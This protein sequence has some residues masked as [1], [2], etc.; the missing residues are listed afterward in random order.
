MKSLAAKHHPLS[1]AA[2]QVQLLE[3]P[4]HDIP[5]FQETLE[6]HGI[7]SLRSTALGTLQ[8]NIGKMCNQTCVHCHVDAGPDRKE[9]MDRPTMEACLQAIDAHQIGIVDITGGAPEMHPD[10]RWFVA[11]VRKRGARIIV[12]CNLTIIVSN[13]KY[14]DLPEFYRSHGVEVVCSLP[15]YTAGRTDRQRGDGVFERSIEALRLLNAVGYGTGDSGKVLNMVYNP[16]G[17][18]LPGSQSDLELQFKKA[19]LKDHGIRFDALFTITNLPISRFLEHLQNSGNYEEYMEKLVNAFNPVTVEGLMC[20][21][22]VSVGHDGIL[23]DCDFNQMLEMPLS[24]GM[25]RHISDLSNASVIGRNIVTGRHCFG[26][27][28]GAGS[29]CGGATT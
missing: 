14:R 24:A 7:R 15:F 2:R 1:A 29:S 22:M 16:A 8:V 19:L 5:G 3:D 21:T 18:F 25:P 10:F 12:R 17:A 13:K 11:E 26:C 9:R 23:Y 28:A 4:D 20:R 27:T 6:R